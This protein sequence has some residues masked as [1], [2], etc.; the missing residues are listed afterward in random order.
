MEE[1]SLH[2][3]CNNGK[4]EEIFIPTIGEHNIYNAMSAILV[5]LCLN[6]L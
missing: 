4:K 5:G 2:Y 3:M 1:D 6:I